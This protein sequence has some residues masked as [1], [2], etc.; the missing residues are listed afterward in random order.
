MRASYRRLLLGPFASSSEFDL[1][2][3][4][5]FLVLD[6]DWVCVY[7]PAVPLENLREVLVQLALL[8]LE[9]L[10]TTHGVCFYVLVYSFRLQIEEPYLP[11]RPGP[12]GGG[13]SWRLP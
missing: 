9:P 3:S 7:R 2:K 10:A 13:Y 1:G 4:V 12:L 5:F 8:L 11:T 6:A